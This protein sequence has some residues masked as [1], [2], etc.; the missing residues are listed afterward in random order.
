MLRDWPS[1]LAR[2]PTATLVLAGWGLDRLRIDAPPRTRVLGS[3]ARAADALAE[4]SVLA[5]P[6]PPTSGPKVKVVE[7]LAHG[8]P[9]VTTPAGVEGLR[10]GPDDGAVVAGPATFAAALAALLGD[11]ERRARLA[12]DGRT[13]VLAAHAPRAAARARVEALRSAAGAS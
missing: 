9:V 1:V 4:A 6:C 12:V 10:L 3:V 11:D 5:F 2:V 13:A 8:R 7:A